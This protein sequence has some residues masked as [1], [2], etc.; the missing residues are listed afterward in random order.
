MH[1]WKKNQVPDKMYLEH[2]SFTSVD[3]IST[4]D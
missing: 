1:D 3:I 2:H 4:Q